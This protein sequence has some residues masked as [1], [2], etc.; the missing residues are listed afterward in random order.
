M[1]LIR[2]P[3]AFSSLDLREL[4]SYRGVLLRKAKQRVL[5]EYDRM[6]LGFLWAVS[7]PL[8]MVLVFWLFRGL[9]DAKTGVSISYPL[10]V[11]TGLVGWFFF[12]DAVTGVGSSLQRDA[13]LIQ[14]VYFPRLISPLSHLL[15]EGYNLGLA[16]LPLALLMAAFGEYPDEKLLLLPLVLLQITLLALGV[17]LVF[18]TLVL[19]SRDWDR[20]LRL[21]LYVGLWIS[22]VI[23]SLDMIPPEYEMAYLVNPMGGS[24]LALRATLFE[25]FEFDWSSWGYSA[26]FTVLAL[27]I[28]LLAFQRGER[29]LADRL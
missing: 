4:L 27:G 16:A 17:G 19:R 10:Y 14:K 25:R 6:W 3:G 18:A 8:L 1:T 12:A 2:P 28:G 21:C 13:G 24:L 23:Y 9:A 5:V 11:Y 26:G 29:T 22:P 15:A 7:R 20:F